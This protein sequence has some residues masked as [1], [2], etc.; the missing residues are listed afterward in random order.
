M[1]I[2][3]I[4]YLIFSENGIDKNNFM[5]YNNH[6][7]EHLFHVWK[8]A[9][10][11]NYERNFMCK[12]C[13]QSICDTCCPNFS[14]YIPGVGSPHSFCSSCG[15]GIYGGES[16]YL[17]SHLAFCEECSEGLSLSELAEIS[18]LPKISYLIEALGGEHRQD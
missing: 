17:I 15:G 8:F 2:A 1:L 5:V 6:S 4:F 10:S 7:I 13:G 18:G 9:T 11:K 3:V 14:G 16:Y 12:E